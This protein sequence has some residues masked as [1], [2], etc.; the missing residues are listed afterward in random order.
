VPSAHSRDVP[1]CP[2]SPQHHPTPPSLP[3]APLPPTSTFFGG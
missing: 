2:P 3:Y 1:P